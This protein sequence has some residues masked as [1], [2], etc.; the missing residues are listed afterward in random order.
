[1]MKNHEL[2]GSV[3][4]FSSIAAFGNQT[5][6]FYS[7]AK[8]GVEGFT[9]SAAKEFGPFGIRVNAVRPGPIDTP[10]VRD[11]GEEM[12]AALTAMIPMHRIGQPNEVAE[13]CLFLASDRS[14]FVNGAILDIHGGMY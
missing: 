6:P 11:C 2:P 14:T 7:A 13:A 5:T 4:N 10:I 9:K 8:A 1:M 3:V 12:L